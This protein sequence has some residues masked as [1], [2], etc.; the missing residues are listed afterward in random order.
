MRNYLCRYLVPLIVALSLLPITVAVAESG[1]ALKGKE[2][3]ALIAGN[4]VEG[5]RRKPGRGLLETVQQA[6]TFRTY[7]SADGQLVETSRGGPQSA[8]DVPAHGNWQ[9]KKGKLCIQFSDSLTD[10]GKQKCYRVR[11]KGNG[12]YELLKGGK[13]NR[14]WD[15]VLP[16]NPHGLK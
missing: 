16:G 11:A 15:R 12:T 6:V 3:K 14:T 13:L 1:N 2:I 9:V 5:H 7:F 10:V 8:G 4:T